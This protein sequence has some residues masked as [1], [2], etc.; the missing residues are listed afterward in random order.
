MLLRTASMGVVW[1]TILKCLVAGSQAAPMIFKMLGG[2]GE[3]D[4]GG[5]GMDRYLG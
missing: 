1:Q 3:D 2:G 5:Q 4:G